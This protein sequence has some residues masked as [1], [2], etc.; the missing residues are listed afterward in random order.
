MKLVNKERLLEEL[1]NSFIKD[2]T[3][4]IH[5]VNFESFDELPKIISSIFDKGLI[6]KGPGGVVSNCEILGTTDYYDQHRLVDYAFYN[7]DGIVVNLYVNIPYVI[8]H[9][10]TLYFIGPF[11]KANQYQKYNQ[12]INSIWLNQYVDDIRLLPSEFIVGASVYNAENDHDVY[13]ENP[14]FLT[15]LDDKKKEEFI[16]K[17]IEDCKDKR[18]IT[19]DEN[20]INGSYNDVLSAIELYKEFKLDD[21]YIQRAKDYI[22]ERYLN[23]KR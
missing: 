23:K 12:S 9:N 20:N 14:N 17:L 21:Y 1:D 10:N 13:Y 19:I 2:S 18:I 7:K 22:V 11:I 16:S 3:I 4:G 8:E 6:N 5:G 15:R